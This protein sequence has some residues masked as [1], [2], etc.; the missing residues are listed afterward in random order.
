M[1]RNGLGFPLAL[2]AAAATAGLAITARL[3]IRST[4]E[5]ERAHPAG[6]RFVEVQ[7]VKLHYIER[8]SGS[9]IVLLHGNGVTS[10]DWEI[11]GILD[12]LVADH[13]VIAFDRPGFGYSERPKNVEWTPVQQAHLLHAALMQLDITRP[14]I[15]GHSWATL[16]ALALALEYPADVRGLV[17]LSGYYFPTL[18]FDVPFA[19]ATAIPFLGDVLRY[20]IA[21]VVGRLMSPLL[22]RQLFAPAPVPDRFK[23]F[24]LSMSLRPSQLRASAQEAQLMVAS[25]K[26]LEPRYGD[27]KVPVSII[28]GS[29][30]M[31][32]NAMAQSNKLARLIS[33]HDAQLISGAGHM[34]HYF[35]PALVVEAATSDK[36]IP[37]SV[38]GT[39]PQGNH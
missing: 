33:G 24:P 36:A 28:A 10:Q 9:P 2:S 8:G 20:T 12:G 25:A 13:R 27:L 16:V 19:S 29:G 11:S 23:N 18:R 5:T 26:S 37:A 32:A 31:I 38:D 34:V 4:R 15:V 21:P 1:K 17:L 22:V 39:R 30:D 6:G 35:A 3:V 7:G 14:V